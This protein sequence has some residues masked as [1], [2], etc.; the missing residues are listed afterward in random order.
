MP[1]L[2][3]L[4]YTVW[5]IVSSPAKAWEEIFVQEDKQNVQTSFVYPLI[6]ICGLATF[7]GSLSMLDG[8]A[9]QVAM[10]KAGSLMVSLFGGFYLAAYLVNLYGMKVLKLESQPELCQRFVGYS[11]ALIFL[12]YIL[13]GIFPSFFILSWLLQFYTVWIIWEGAQKLMQV[14]EDR[15]LVYTLVTSAITMVSP[16]VLRIIFDNLSRILS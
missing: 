9:F 10:S 3:G 7:L 11:M 2:K 16:F 6:G 15:L 13:L 1:F 14:D 8:I 4:F 12:L 5:L